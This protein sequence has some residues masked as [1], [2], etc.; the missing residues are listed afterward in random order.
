MT[1]EH[2]HISELRG[3]SREPRLDPSHAWKI[4]TH[5]DEPAPKCT[6]CGAMA[7]DPAGEQPCPMVRSRA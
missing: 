3:V 7:T 6:A 2:E 5:L 1:F 4:A